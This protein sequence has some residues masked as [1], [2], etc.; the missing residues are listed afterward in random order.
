MIDR[1]MVL[2]E[3]GPS[4]ENLRGVDGKSYSLASFDDKQ[5]L[6]F[7]F[8]GNGCPT[9]KATEE[10]L[11]TIQKDY[12]GKG[13]QVVLV[14]SNNASIS[15]PD[16]L[17]EMK[18]R[19]EENHYIFPYLKDEGAV[20]AREF[21]ALTTPHAF[22]FDRD[23]KLRY[24]GRVDNARQKSLVT[25]NDVRNALDDLLISRQVRTPETT[26][27]GCAIVW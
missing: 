25:I 10:R 21:G 17:G 18:K 24:A 27:F 5:V 23:R 6:V 1:P 9:C 8:M 20:L 14:N 19:A 11:I 7:V 2:G 22:I 16:T 13:V 3:K 4:F 12:L 15:P 26:S